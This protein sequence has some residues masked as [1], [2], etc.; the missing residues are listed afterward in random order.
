MPALDLNPGDN[1]KK[2]K[3]NNFRLG[4]FKPPFIKKDKD[5]NKGN[6]V[7]KNDLGGVA[8]SQGGGAE[9]SAASA[10]PPLEESHL[11]MASEASRRDEGDRQRRL[12]IQE[13]QDLAYAIALSKAE[14]AS[15]S[16]Q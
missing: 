8:G 5:K 13:E 16:N 1:S 10:P 11:K 12:K 15:L 4:H 7:I 14:A 3:K 6:K 2:E 9:S